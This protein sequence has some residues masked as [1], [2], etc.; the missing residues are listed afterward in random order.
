M[1]APVHIFDDRLPVSFCWALLAVVCL[2]LALKVRDKLLA[3][4]SL[5]VFAV[6]G[7]KVLWYDLNHAVPLIRI[8]C[9]IILGISFYLG[10]WLYRKVGEID[11]E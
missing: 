4:S 5:F 7:A 6:S 1:A 11:P 2:V 3:Q 9:L 10:G 8:A